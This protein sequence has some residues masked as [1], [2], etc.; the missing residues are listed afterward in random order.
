MTLGL[1]IVDI[2]G[3]AILAGLVLRWGRNFAEIVASVGE[4]TAKV[5]RELTLRDIAA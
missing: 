1:R 4:A 3:A 5:A 2:I